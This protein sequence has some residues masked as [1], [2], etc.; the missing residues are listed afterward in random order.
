MRPFVALLGFVLGSVASITFSLFGVAVVVFVLQSDYP[1]LD[2]ELRPLLAN[3]A[4]FTF[5]TALAAL[6]FYLEIKS[7]AWRRVSEMALALTLLAFGVYYWP[8]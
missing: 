5:L 1:R 7:L 4:V 6:S 2:G 3:L 8:A